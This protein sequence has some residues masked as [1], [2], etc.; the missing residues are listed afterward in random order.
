MDWKMKMAALGWWDISMV[1]HGRDE[2][3]CR[4]FERLGLL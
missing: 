2:R 3:G 1:G 4:L